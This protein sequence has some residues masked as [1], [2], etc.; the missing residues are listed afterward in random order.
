MYVEMI[1]RCA[2]AA[3]PMPLNEATLVVTIDPRI[4]ECAKALAAHFG[5]DDA[6]AVS[7]ADAA[8]AVIL[9]WLEQELS[10]TTV[11]ECGNIPNPEYGRILTT[12]KNLRALYAAMCEQARKEILGHVR[13]RA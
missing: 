6:A 10:D 12:P 13:F 8:R 7:F 11:Y 2:I 5:H 4:I 1:R 3:S 9:K